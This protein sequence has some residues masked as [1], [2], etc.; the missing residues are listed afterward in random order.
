MSNLAAHTQVAM[1]RLALFSLLICCFGTPVLAA[2]PA[3]DIA[4]LEQDFNAAYAANQFDQ[5]FGYYRDDAVFWFP[6]GRTDVPGYKKEWRD[7]LD[8]GA[9]I[10]AG[11][12]SDLHVTLSPSGDAAIASYLLRL[13]QREADK[14]V[15]T[16]DFQ[17]SD[18]W[19]KS[20]AG[21]KIVHV[22]YSAAP[23]PVKPTHR[24]KRA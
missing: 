17:E 20:E 3:A 22:H 18:V 14:K 23:K 13:T 11:V 7:F 24:H 12:V 9:G 19:F 1:Q 21:W 5:Y 6:E 15:H 16:D 10:V 8:S 2:D 4:H